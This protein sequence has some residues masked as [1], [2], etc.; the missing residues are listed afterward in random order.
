MG[1]SD[2]RGPRDVSYE[3]FLFF[4]ERTTKRRLNNYEEQASRMQP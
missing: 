1:G 3:G 4:R 2:P